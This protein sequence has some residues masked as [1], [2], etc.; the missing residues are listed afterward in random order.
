MLS[1]LVVDDEAPIRD[2]VAYCIEREPQRDLKLIAKARNG[3]EGVEMALQYRPDLVI[4]DIMMPGLD[5]LGMMKQILQSLPY[6]NFI[7]L[8]NYAEFSYARTALAYGAKHYLLKSEMRATD[9]IEAIETLHQ[10]KKDLLQGKQTDMYANGFL[11][12]YDLYQHAGDGD[13]ARTFM[14]RHGMQD[15][16][17]YCLIGLEETDLF[18]QRQVIDNM[19]ALEKPTF[20]LA[21]L[22]KHTVIVFLQESTCSALNARIQK[23]TSDLL[24]TTKKTIGVSHT[25]N[26]LSELLTA[27]HE[28]DQMV[29]AGFFYPQERQLTTSF[30][31]SSPIIDRQQ[32]W[33]AS[34]EIFEALQL[35]DSNKTR[36]LLTHWLEQL[37]RVGLEDIQWAKE[38]CLRMLF[39]VEERVMHTQQNKITE[40]SKEPDSFEECKKRIH[41]SLCILDEALCDTYS[42]RIQKALAYMNEHYSQPIS[43]VETAD[44][45]SLSAEYFSRLFK[46]KTGENFSVH[47]MMLRL[48]QA[49]KLLTE[50]NDKIYDIA[51]QVGYASASHFS[52]LYKKYMGINPEEV[53]KE[54][55]ISKL[56]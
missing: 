24:T 13:F 21:A 30:F 26:D 45:V 41:D 32:I 50:T 12:I 20:C 33:K 10:H 53:R 56:R 5:G 31:H 15:A 37:S 6:T 17:P 28:T 42:Q 14:H 8:S 55:E 11:D 23:L 44:H 35:Q 19:I 29:L 22:Q 47:L 7:I 54:Q 48:Q 16:L 1:I 2:W 39:T 49:Q 4:T 9:L 25:R 34:T 43:L 51:N 18:I 52:K 27:L 38:A 46:E 36:T 40:A 3:Q